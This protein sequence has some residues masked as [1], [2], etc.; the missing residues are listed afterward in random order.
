VFPSLYP[1]VWRKQ[2]GVRADKWP[3]PVIRHEYAPGAI[4]FEEPRGH[5]AIAVKSHD[6]SSNRSALGPPYT[7]EFHDLSCKLASCKTPETRW[8][9]ETH[10]FSMFFLFFSSRYKNQK[11]WG[12][13]SKTPSSE[14]VQ[15]TCLHRCC[16]EK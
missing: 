9:L 10:I 13:A 11:N 14:L 4:I 12:Q 15:G 16:L 5:L 3:P 7:I 8:H 1:P 6:F 2:G